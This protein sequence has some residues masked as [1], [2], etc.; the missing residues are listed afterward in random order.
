MTT[1]EGEGLYL[2]IYTEESD[3]RTYN[4]GRGILPT[5]ES[6]EGFGLIHSWMRECT[7]THHCEYSSKKSLRHRPRRLIDVGRKDSSVELC[8]VEQDKFPDTKDYRYVALS[9]CWGDSKPAITTR[10]TL[11]ERTK[12][13]PFSW[14][15]KTF[16]DAI[17]I[18]RAIGIRYLWIDSLCIIQ[19]SLEDWREESAK[20]GQIYAQS[21]LTICAAGARDSNEGCFITRPLPRIS[22]CRMN[23]GFY[24][25]EWIDSM[26]LWTPEAIDSR[27][28]CLQEITFAPRVL[29]CGLRMM[30]WLC[31]KKATTEQGHMPFTTKYGP[32]LNQGNWNWN[33]TVSNYT[34]RFLSYE[35][36][37]LVAISGLAR[38]FGRVLGGRYLAGLWEQTL[39]TDLLWRVDIRDK[40]HLGLV[41]RPQY[42]RSPTWSWAC[43]DGPIIFPGED[44]EERPTYAQVLRVNVELAGAD[45]F[46]EIMSAYLRITGLC[47]EVV[48]RNT[49]SAVFP[50][51][52]SLLGENEPKSK[53]H[54]EQNCASCWFDV[55][56]E[57]D[58][59]TTML[60]CLRM[61]DK[62]GL[63]L[64][65]TE[66]ENGIYR[67]VGIATWIGNWILN[68]TRKELLII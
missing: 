7:K 26:P 11:N 47:A 18:T 28:W 50:S 32:R 42:Y 64:L 59:S 8:L 20:M 46:G 40:T 3:R 58:W 16:Q 30:A 15:P 54:T 43:L 57:E 51:C 5:A 52:F 10:S 2:L 24:I 61:T 49:T 27:G 17:R 22:A 4:V 13:I 38:H 25:A 66:G 67:R 68:S 9:H 41:R 21:T 63:L 39:F 31:N 56:D 53:K 62:Y 19:D 12:Q 37:K 44:I 23:A 35:R 14:L 60:I 29:I 1:S 6:E 65:P 55:R 36:D 33:A 45:P 48:C 34:R